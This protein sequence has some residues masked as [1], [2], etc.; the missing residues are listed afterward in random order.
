VLTW[1]LIIGLSLVSLPVQAQEADITVTNP[2]AQPAGE[3]PLL[4]AMQTAQTTLDDGLATMNEATLRRAA[5]QFEKIIE[6]YGLDPRHFDAY[7]SA[8]YIY[9]EYLQTIPDFE[10]AV[11][12][13][14]LLV[15]S[16]PSSYTEVVDALILKAH[17]EYRC[18]RDYR[19]AQEDL[20][21]VLNN[22]ALSA[23][24]GDRETDVK[25]LLAK[26][27]QKLAEYDQAKTIWDELQISNP[28]LDSEGR[29]QWVNNAANWLLVSDNRV[30]LF[31]E[32]DIDRNTY[33]TC[34]ARLHEALDLVDSAWSLTSSSVIDVYLY[35]SGDS[36]FEYTLKNKGFALPVDAEIH[37]C[38]ADI[39]SIPHLVGWVSTQRVSSRPDATVFPMFRAGFQHYFMESRQELDRK[40]ARVIYYDGGNI[41]DYE[42]LFPLSFDYTYTS[43]Y[44]TMAA[45]FMHYLIEDR[46][47]GVGA[48]QSFY[49][50][51][52]ARPASRLVSPIMEAFLQSNFDVGEAGSWQDQTLVPDQVYGLFRSVLGIDLS[53]ELTSWQGSLSDEI[54]GVEAELGSLTGQV[55]TVQVDLTTPENAVRS[56]WAAYQAGDI[57]SLIQSSTGDLGDM[58][59]EAKQLYVDQGILEQVML[60]YFIRPNRNAVMSITGSGQF[61]DDLWVFD[62][63]IDHGEN[64]EQRTIAVRKVGSKWQVDSNG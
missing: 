35:K 21:S 26:C 48:L 57:D 5:A 27:R 62:I 11:N 14:T 20:S 8:A 61:A 64:V 49:R 12:L 13:L 3:D 43:E 1:A 44:A 37:L 58:L 45:S 6:D 18:L 53:A 54:A 4:Q 50:L 32:K 23:E 47:V 28:E 17:I 41:P 16:H 22:I 40:A 19:A 15:N 52:W 34:M 29:L 55:Q 38:P 25:V 9:I 63:S 51:L 39:P 42:I 10:H 7:F 59:V 30:R 60:D 24:L 2:P 56:W 31:F 36:L 33:T 46:G